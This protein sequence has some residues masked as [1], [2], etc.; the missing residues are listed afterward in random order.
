MLLPERADVRL[1][2]FDLQGRRT[3]TMNSS[4]APGEHRVIW[5]RKTDAGGI[6]PRGIYSVRLTAGSRQAVARL[7]VR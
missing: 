5:D 7:T 6:A 2:I 1:E 3:R 4:F